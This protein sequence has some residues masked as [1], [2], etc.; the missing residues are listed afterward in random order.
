MAINTTQLGPGTLTLGAGALEQNEQLTS[1]KVT[2]SESVTA[3]DDIKVLSGGVLDGDETASYSF[4]LEGNFLQDLGALASVVDWSWTNMG[5]EQA[6]VFTPNTAATSTVT[7]VI[8][9]VPL[10][11][12]GDEVNAGPMR[13]DFTWRIKGTPTFDNTPA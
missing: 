8:I 6:F 10:T 13:S 5:T 7:G 4:V 12:G 2:P 11:I 3:T 1:C 9:P